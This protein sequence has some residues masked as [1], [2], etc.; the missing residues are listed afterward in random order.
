MVVLVSASKPQ[1]GTNTQITAA[2]ISINTQTINN[3]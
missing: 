3:L 2:D 1:E